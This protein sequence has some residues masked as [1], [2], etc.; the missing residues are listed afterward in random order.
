MFSLTRL[1][2]RRAR[3]ERLTQA[4][5]GLTFT[6]VLSLVPLLAVSF[7]L[8]TRIPAFSATGV[9]IRQHLLQGV[10]PPDI[11]RTVLKHLAQFTANTGALT[12]VGALFVLASAFFMLLSVENVLNRM[13][14]VKKNRPIHKRLGLYAVMLVLGP[15]LLGASLWATS[16]VLTASAGLIV[17]P[18]SAAH[19]ALNLVPVLLGTVGLASLFYFVPHAKV[20]RRDA[21]IG[22]LLASISFELGKRGFALYLLK[23]PTYKTVYGT[24]APML[25]FLV[26]VYFSWLVTLAAALIAANL[27]RAGKPAAP[28][29]LSRA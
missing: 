8:F 18:S 16:Y 7:A 4:A 17:N 20:R 1:T 9:A 13:W 5:G 2:I 29:R 23:I 11:A 14:L 10:L 28:R 24:F 19:I 25:L 21:I 22:G 6:T 27:P 3:E 26:W 15:P 12:W